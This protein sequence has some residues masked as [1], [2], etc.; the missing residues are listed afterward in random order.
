MRRAVAI[1]AIAAGLAGGEPAQANWLTKLGRVAD[2]APSA[3]VMKGAGALDHATVHIKTLPV[4]S[5]ALAAELGS[6]GH[7][8]FVSRSGEKFT[9]GT[10]AELERVAGVLLPNVPKG[11]RL[12][13]YVTEA[14]LFRDRAR[15]GDLAAHGD[16]RIVA[17]KTS[18]RLLTQGTGAGARNFVELRPNLLVEATG[19][20]PY[21]EAMFQMSRTLGQSRV[22]VVA[23]DPEGPV[24]LAS[25][26]RLDPATGRALTDTVR[27]D[28]FVS[29]LHKLRGQTALIVA[30]RD[31]DALVFRPAS[32]PERR[33]AWADLVAEAERYDVNLLIVRA[34][35]PTQPGSRNWLW[36]KVGVKGLDDAIA[37]ATM[38]DVVAGLLPK[39]ARHAVTVTPRGVHQTTIEMVAVEGLAPIAS[40]ASQIGD[41]VVGIAAEIAGNIVQSGVEAVVTSSERQRELDGRIVPGIPS[42][43]QAFYIVAFA[44]GLVGA[45]VARG[46]WGRIWPM[47]SRGEYAGRIGYYAAAFLRGLVF[48]L[49]F[50]P[51]VAIA[52]TP[53]NILRKAWEIVTTPLRVWHW[54]R[55]RT[56]A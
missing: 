18:H 4:K 44:F 41:K 49:V 1:L 55:G 5:P 40:T 30:R 10:T 32:G 54:W 37:S 48:W 16:V 35:T 31:G 51:M 13:F 50:A 22:R 14:S 8:T 3:R 47:E 39:T 9:A 19:P 52:S 23:L 28:H 7:W 53:I 25:G 38:A 21:A 27:P 33:I 20:G 36:Q 29:S 24:T 43:Y 11:E 46:W 15:L 6:E 45:P 2:E 26:P 17:G 12:Q 42:L 56:A 34:S